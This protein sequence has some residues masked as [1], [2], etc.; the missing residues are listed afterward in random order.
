MFMQRRKNTI[1]GSRVSE[2]IKNSFGKKE[3]YTEYERTDRMLKLGE[4]QTLEIMKKVEFGVCAYLDNEEKQAYEIRIL[5]A[6]KLGEE[7][8][9]KMLVPLI[10]QMLLVMAVVLAP[11]M[12]GFMKQKGVF[13]LKWR[14]FLE[15]ESGAGVVELILII[16]V[17]IGVVLI[18]KEQVTE[19]VE[20]I[21]KTITKEAGKV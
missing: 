10:L 9:T 16:V 19:L 11:A 7:A 4:K 21:F 18:F 14:E 8:S 3:K 12:M 1:C 6:K 20:D 13:M 5:N 2:K 15:D 17:L